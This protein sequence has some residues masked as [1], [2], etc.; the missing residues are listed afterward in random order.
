LVLPDI[1][2]PPR[3]DV[4][5]LLLVWDALDVDL[6]QA[7]RDDIGEPSWVDELEDA[8]A[9][10]VTRRPF[11]PEHP[12]ESRKP[13]DEEWQ[14]L[15]ESI[16]VFR[17][18]LEP[19]NWV[20]PVAQEVTDRLVGHVMDALARASREGLAPVAVTYYASLAASLPRIDAS[21]PVREATMLDVA[22]RGIRVGPGTNVEDVLSFREKHSSQTGRF[23]AALIDLAASI[24]PDS[25]A[26]AEE[27]FALLKNRVEP[28]L[29]ALDDVMS[30]GR[31]SFAWGMLLG[32][33]AT[34]AAGVDVGAAIAEGGQVATRGLRYAFNRDRLIREHPYGFLYR[35]RRDFAAGSPSAPV[36]TNPEQEI[37]ES[38]EGLVGAA[39]SATVQAAQEGQID[40]TRLRR[41]LDG[42]QPGMRDHFDFGKGPSDRSS[43]GH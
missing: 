1:G 39:I 25:P 38:F 27:A 15:A 8:G 6:A 41:T 32:A 2:L 10:R 26:P 28:A 11:H 24:S 9:L 5:S 33:S 17:D 12:P 4:L 20:E 21:A 34:V 22:T 42:V 14:E 31:I 16:D 36:I 30:R 7:G 13:F 29:A 37:K 19:N 43:P 35:A 23:R 18:F 40:S 3:E